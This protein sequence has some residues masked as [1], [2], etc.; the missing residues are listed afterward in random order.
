MDCPDDRAPTDSGPVWW[1]EAQLRPAG[2]TLS[3]LSLT[4]LHLDRWGEA[5]C[6]AQRERTYASDATHKG[7]GFSA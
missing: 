7:K 2:V 6:S 5:C 1:G 4:Q 3:C